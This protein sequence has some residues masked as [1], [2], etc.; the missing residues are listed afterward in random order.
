LAYVGN[1]NYFEI[2]L[3]HH[4]TH[5]LN[6][7][8]IASSWVVIANCSPEY[9]LEQACLTRSLHFYLLGVWG[10]LQ[11]RALNERVD[12]VVLVAGAY[13]REVFTTC[14]AGKKALGED[15]R[16]LKLRRWS[17]LRIVALFGGELDGVLAL[18][19]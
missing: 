19:R 14:C 3:W 9:Q 15:R 16:S 11:D 7:F 10:C 5:V 4:V 1:P 2:Y 6:V 12:D 13:L 8:N 18:Q 17:G